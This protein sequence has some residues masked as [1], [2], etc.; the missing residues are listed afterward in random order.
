MVTSCTSLGSSVPFMGQTATFARS[1]SVVFRR[2]TAY[3]CAASFGLTRYAAECPSVGL[4]VRTNWSCGTTTVRMMFV[5]A[6]V[7]RRVGAGV[8]ASVTAVG[9]AEM[10]GP[11]VGSVVGVLR[12]GFASVAYA[13]TASASSARLQ[14]ATTWI[15][16]SRPNPGVIARPR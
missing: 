9:A 5:G 15:A 2:R 12:H 3:V 7:G 10:L 8:G 11:G 1:G 4:A 13:A 16:P 6:G 14:V